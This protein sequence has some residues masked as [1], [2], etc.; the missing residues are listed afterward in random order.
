M[1]EMEFE[2]REHVAW[3][4]VTIWGIISALADGSKTIPDVAA[5]MRELNEGGVGELALLV[6]TGHAAQLLQRLAEVM[7]ESVPDAAK[8]YAQFNQLLD[9]A[10]DFHS[11]DDLD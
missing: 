1:S 8:R 10:A 11:D 5:D 2:G 9:I 4:D 6:V 3:I 7:G